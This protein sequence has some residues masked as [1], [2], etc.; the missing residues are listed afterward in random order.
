MLNHSESLVKGT[1][2]KVCLGRELDF[3]GAIMGVS[4]PIIIVQG[5]DYSDYTPKHTPNLTPVNFRLVTARPALSKMKDS[6]IYISY[7]GHS[8]EK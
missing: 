4:T 6:S 3:T 5:C 7:P 1:L 8:Q 2:G